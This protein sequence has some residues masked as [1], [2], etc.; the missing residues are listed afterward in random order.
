MRIFTCISLAHYILFCS[1]C[2]LRILYNSK[3]ILMATPLRTNAAI[4]MRLHH[5]C[6]HVFQLYKLSAHSKFQVAPFENFVGPIVQ[7]EE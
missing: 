4:V 6:I 7:K 1:F 2:S 5:L 3:F